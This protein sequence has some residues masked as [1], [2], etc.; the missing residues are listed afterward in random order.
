[1]PFMDFQAARAA[2][3]DCQIRPNDVTDPPIVSA[4]LTT[5]REDFVPAERRSVAYS[6]LEIETSPGRS[7]WTARDTSKLI[8]LAG[9]KPGES[10]LVI[11][12]GSGYEAALL[13]RV[14][15]TVIALEDSTALVDAMT[16]RFGELN[17]DRAVA[18]EGSLA[19]GLPD[20]APFSVIYV[21]GM[22]ETI[23]DAWLAQ[24]AEGG[25]L[26][27][28]IE[29]APGLGRGRVYTKALGGVAH[30]D[31]FDASPPKWTAF[32]RPK[33]FTF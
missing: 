33:A 22:I 21:C 28:V 4:F 24:L 25:R 10:V 32:N 5:P 18:I 17:L 14:A 11:G 29:T 31:A 15:D 12:A 9:L 30:R 3:V 2:M 19:A 20:Q 16:E 23:P 7:L 8:K 6:E 26:V 27:A 1:M 13:S